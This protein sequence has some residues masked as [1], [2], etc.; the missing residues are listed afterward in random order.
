MHTD[1]DTHTCTQKQ[2]LQLQYKQ[3]RPPSSLGNMCTI[4]TIRCLR[5]GCRTIRDV[6]YW[7]GHLKSNLSPTHYT[8]H[9]KQSH[10]ILHI[11]FR[12][13]LNKMDA[14][15]HTIFESHF[16]VVSIN[17]IITHTKRLKKCS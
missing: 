16:E 17:V 7:F 14:E 13:V 9:A 8:R 11:S 10:L 5:D 3:S 6:L 15:Q 4:H 1:T 2:D 12:H